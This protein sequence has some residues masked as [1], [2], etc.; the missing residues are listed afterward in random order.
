ME[1]NDNKE[2]TKY[3]ACD[4]IYLYITLKSSNR[5]VRHDGWP[6]SVN[7]KT[8]RVETAIIWK[9]NMCNKCVCLTVLMPKQYRSKLPLFGKGNM[10]NKCV[11][12]CVCVSYR[13]PP[14]KCL[15]IHLRS[16]F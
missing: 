13:G 9:G 8:R 12:V 11:C 6:Y 4:G 7:V 1:L 10:C 2:I 3:K 5:I 15:Q 16:H 14:L